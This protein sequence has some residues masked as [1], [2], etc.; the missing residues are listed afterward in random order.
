MELAA[1][2]IS[3]RLRPLEPIDDRITIVGV[4][5]SDIASLKQWPFSDEVLAKLIAEIKKQNP[6]AIGLDLY[7]NLPVKPGYDRLVKVYQTTPNLIGIQKAIQDKFSSAIP[8][9]LVLS[10]LG[11]V[12]ANDILVDSDGVVRRGIL[13]PMPEGN[14]ALP[15]LGLATAMLYLQE[16]GINPQADRRG[17]L[18]LGN[19]VFTPFEKNDGSYVR[20]DAGGYQILLNFRGPASIF[21]TVSVMDVLKHR[22]PPYLIRDRIVLIGAKAKSLNDSFYTPYSAGF[23]SSPVKTAGVE[24]QA[25]IA[26][27]ILNAVLNNRPLIQ[28]WPNFLEDLWTLLWATFIPV[29]SWK[30]RHNKA[31]LF[32]LQIPLVIALAIVSLSLI[33]Y[34]CFLA[35]WWIPIIPPLVALLASAVAIGSYIYVTQL[36]ELNSK[37]EQTVNNLE[38]ALTEL[39]RSQLQ[40]VQSEKMS[41]LGQLVSGVA[42]E[43]NNPI[44]FVSGNLTHIQQYTQDLIEHLKLYQENFPDP[45]K[46]ITDNAKEIDLEYTLEDLPE[47][48][49]SMQIGIDRIK[50]ISISLRTFSR[51]DTS[52]KVDCNIHDGIDSTLMILKHRL[53]ANDKRP[54]IKIVKKYSPLPPVN[55]YLGQLNQVIMNLLSNAIDAFDEINQGRSSEEIKANPNIITIQTEIS[56]NN[57]M[58]AIR[59]KDNGPGIPESVQQKIFEQLFTTKGVGK[60]T[61]LGL[62]ISRQIVEET[63]KGKLICISA[64]GK[65]AEFVIE[66]PI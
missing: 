5:E 16:K 59:I 19:T 53:K 64:P 22:V 40:L 42:H 65:G 37:L 33:Y 47:L 14:E 9:P 12:S 10:K 31:N 17:F 51:S 11:Q 63:H 28:V 13:Y 55:C 43:I 20:A 56:E 1:L 45:G 48:I 30:F 38:R 61:G 25:N 29:F 3:F 7:R 52:N 36:Q 6:T 41:A 4:E 57:S 15:S 66:I 35:G 24:L 54:E 58:V 62:S 2:D 44:G 46:E 27:Q 39:Q 49:K 50:E 32:I 18:Q 21:A 8:P 26:S 60:G 23:R 34:L